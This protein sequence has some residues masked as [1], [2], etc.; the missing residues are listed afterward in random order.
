MQAPRGAFVRH[1]AP[2][3]EDHGAFGFVQHAA[4]RGNGQALPAA[5]R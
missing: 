4:A 3:E 5:D 2:D 1:R